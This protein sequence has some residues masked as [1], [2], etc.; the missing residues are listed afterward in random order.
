M[1]L[2]I[3]EDFVEGGDL[4]F[5]VEKGAKPTKLNMTEAD[6]RLAS[7]IDP[8]SLMVEIEA[9]HAAPH[10]TR[11]FTTYMPNCLKS[12]VKTWTEPYVRPLIR[13]HNEKDGKIIGRVI[14]A[15]YKTSGTFSGTPAL[16]L[17]VNVP[18]KEAKEEVQN[19][20]AQ[21]VSIGVMADDV[22]CSICG[23]QLSDGEWCEHE[24]GHRY[25]NERTGEMEE[26][27]WEIHSMEAKELSY[28]I[29]PS[30]M[31]AK[32]VKFYP[33]SSSPDKAVK[34]SAADG[35]SLQIKT[36]SNNEGVTEMA[37]KQK[38]LEEQLAKAQ[39]KISGLE[40]ELSDMKTAKE[41]LD[42]DVKE[43]TEAKEAADKKVE[44]LESEKAELS[45]KV[46]ELTAAKEALDSEKEESAKL[47]ESLESQLAETKA[48]LKASMIENLQT[49]RKLGGKKELDVEKL[50]ARTE[51]SIQDS[52]DDIKAEI[53][54]IK[55]STETGKKDIAE[56]AEEKVSD[57]DRL[58]A[59]GSVG[60]ESLANEDK[61]NENV[62]ENSAESNMNLREG[63]ADVFSGI[64]SGRAL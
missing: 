5:E 25:K 46:E 55:E 10:H 60:T 9:M 32:N 62:K 57:K 22:R 4:Q 14:D 23:A 40:K 17:T 31:Y 26:C 7:T 35:E 36:N 30:D 11:N 34:E 27:C 59:P 20:I 50:K 39:E 1:A 63:L 38:D 53:G 8:D 37:D 45:T 12:S 19:G 16:E 58:P 2:M 33:A 52:I 56:G 47:Q 18:D 15:R 54:D 49:L 48:S 61:T 51:S 28:V 6:N 44:A 42:Q 41:A 43:A 3:H 24:R 21:T 13:H 64:V 29:V